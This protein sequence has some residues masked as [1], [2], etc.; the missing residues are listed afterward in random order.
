[1]LELEKPSYKSKEERGN[2]MYKKSKSYSNERCSFW[3]L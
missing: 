1:M 2:D 3:F